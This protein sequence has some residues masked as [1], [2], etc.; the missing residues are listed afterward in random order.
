MT[1]TG[2]LLFVMYAMCLKCLEKMAVV[3]K[4]VRFLA[5]ADASHEIIIGQLRLTWIG[6]ICFCQ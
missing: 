4:L 1:S 3:L 6:S 2:A 5:H